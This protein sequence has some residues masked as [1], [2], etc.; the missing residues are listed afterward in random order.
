[1][2]D[3]SR[4]THAIYTHAR[5]NYSTDCLLIA[6]ANSQTREWPGQPGDETLTTDRNNSTTSEGS[7]QTATVAF[8]AA[9]QSEE[10]PDMP[11]NQPG[12]LQN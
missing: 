3:L 11:G 6:L 10:S 4:D 8:D 1:M 12:G 9:A 7:R 5:V 2:Y